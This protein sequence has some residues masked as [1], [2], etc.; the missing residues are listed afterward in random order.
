MPLFASLNQPSVIVPADGVFLQAHQ[1][2]DGQGFPPSYR[3]FA[4]Q[5]GWGRL[6]ALWLIYVPLGNHPDSWL[7]QSLA[8]RQWM[9]AFYAEMAHDL[10]LLEPDGYDGIERSLLP[11][12]RSENGEYLAWDMAHRDAAGELPIYVLAPRLGGVRYGAESLGQFVEKCT[13]DVAVKT[14]LGAGYAALPVVFE[15]LPLAD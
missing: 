8:I 1:L 10:F 3:T 14:M 5:L 6:C 15:P 7:V 2:P 12:A 9:D 13:D 11:F 4:T